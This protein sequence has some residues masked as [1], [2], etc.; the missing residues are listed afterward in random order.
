MIE[1]DDIVVTSKKFEDVE[2]FVRE[3]IPYLLMCKTHLMFDLLSPKHRVHYHTFGEYVYDLDLTGII[4]ESTYHNWLAGP[5]I[6]GRKLAAPI[7]FLHEATSIN[8]EDSEESKD[9]VELINSLCIDFLKTLE[10]KWLDNPTKRTAQIEKS[11][12][13]ME[14][15]WLKDN[16]EIVQSH[17]GNWIVVEGQEI[18]AHSPRMSDVLKV[19]RDRGIVSPFVIFI[20]EPSTGVPIG[21]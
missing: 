3:G 14:L 10:N 21:I 18:I 5:C 13:E 17:H 15:R 8:P 9:T 1:S 7:I 6:T 16:S 12:R 20:S 11:K 19:A 2:D 4:E